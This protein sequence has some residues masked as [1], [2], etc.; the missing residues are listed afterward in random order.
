MVCCAVLVLA[1]M[2]IAAVASDLPKLD[3]KTSRVVVFKDGYCMFVKDVTGTPDALGRAVIEDVPESMILGSFW[4]ISE[5]HPVKRTTAKQY[6]SVRKGKQELEKRLE[7]EFSLVNA[8]DNAVKAKLQHFGPGIRWIPTYRISLGKDGKAEMLM[9]AEM[10]NEAE[11]LVNVEADLV[12]GVP[13]FR[14]KEVASPMSFQP[15]LVNFLVTVAPQ[16]AGQMM[17]S[18]ALYTQRAGEFRG[19]LQDE[20]VRPAAV[21]GVPALPPELMGEGAQ[22]LF[23]YKIPKLSLAAGERTAIPIINAKVP[24]RHLY[25]WDVRL[26]RSN[27]EGVPGSGAR[28]GPTKLLKNDVWHFVELTNNTDVPWT[29][30]AALLMDNWLPLGQ[31]LLTYT[32]VGGKVQVPVTVAIDV[33]GTY[34]EQET[35]RDLKALNYNGHDYTRVAKKGTLRVTNYKKEAIDL[36]ATASFGGIATKASD[37]GAMA[38]TD[39]QQEDWTSYSG[40]PGLTGHS[41][42][43][44]RLK[45]GAGETKEVTCE[46]YFYVY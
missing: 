8:K 34:S 39:F 6:I 10:L 17:M 11:D 43:E 22:D 29:T 45:L 20:G 9:Q 3:V 46:Y 41:N 19:K 30:G 28:S 7:V 2:S 42:I 38:V 23:T 18:N 35:G 14:F 4:L 5:S 21:G 16:L 37:D 26:S 15:T 44:W 25:A 31:E 36:I 40:H 27:A 32:S 24:F 1:G 33:R 13:N 12:V